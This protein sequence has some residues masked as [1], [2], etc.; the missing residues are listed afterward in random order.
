MLWN[1]HTGQ[2]DANLMRALDIDPSLL[3]EVHPSAYQFGQTDADWLGAPL[4]IGG[5]AGDQ[6]S[7]LFGQAC[8]KPGM[9]KNT[10][11][12]GC[13][14]LLNT[15]DKAVQSHNGLISTAACQ[16]GPKRSYALEGSV[17]VGGAVVQWLRDGLRAIQRSADVEGLAASVPDSGGVVFVP[18]FTGLGAPYWDPTA[19][20]AIVGLSRGTSIGHIARAALESIAFQS[21][22]LLQ[23]MTRDAVSTISELRVDGGASANNLLLQFQADLLGIPVVRP[24]IIETTALGAAYLAG[25]ATGF[26]R[27]EDEVAQQWRASR[28]FHPVISRD[29]ALSRMAQWEMA[30]AQ[31]RL[32]TTRG[33]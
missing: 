22:A 25:I 31:V 32:P 26:Y 27:G 1:I 14:M 23:A 13:F 12:T 17:F 16:S 24:E 18:S 33:H 10:Y 29:E 9:A 30:V 11:G 7:A 3:P 6:Q 19:Q 20:G 8:F 15:G 21:T 5:M 2:W 28:T 4:T